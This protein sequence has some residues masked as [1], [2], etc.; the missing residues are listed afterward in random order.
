MD[1]KDEKPI[2]KSDLPNSPDS[3]TTPTTPIGESMKEH[4]EFLRETVTEELDKRKGEESI[5]LV[6]G[7]KDAGDMV[8]KGIKDNSDGK[9]IKDADD[10]KNQTDAKTHL[11]KNIRDADR[12]KQEIFLETSSAKEDY[13]QSDDLIDQMIAAL[14]ELKKGK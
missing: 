1:Q 14:Q 11:D 10:N 6:K 2:D 12:K 9:R 3:G 13:S 5:S 7:V 4:M 8:L